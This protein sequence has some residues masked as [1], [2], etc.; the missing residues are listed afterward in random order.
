MNDE[1]L[2]GYEVGG[3]LEAFVAVG[4]FPVA[5]DKGLEGGLVDED[6]VGEGGCWVE[7]GI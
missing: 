3:G 4:W 2:E 7:V 6:C 1:S 5:G